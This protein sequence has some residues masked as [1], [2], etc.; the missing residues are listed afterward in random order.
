MRSCERDL[1]GLFDHEIISM[2][3][4]HT[5][6]HTLSLSLSLSRHI[7][8]Y[9]YIVLLKTTEVSFYIFMF[10]F[11]SFLFLFFQ[12]FSLVFFFLYHISIDREVALH[13]TPNHFSCN[14]YRRRTMDTA[15]RVQILDETYCISHST[16]TLGKGMNPFILPPAMGK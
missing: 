9:I 8:I 5:H 3:Q 16:I 11:Y 14:G 2:F 4:K 7:Y 1:V 15:T 13:Y 10:L 6:T 12:G